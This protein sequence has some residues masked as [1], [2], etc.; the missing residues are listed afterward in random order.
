M[1]V[2]HFESELKASLEN[3]FMLGRSGQT[4]DDITKYINRLLTMNMNNLEKL[5]KSETKE[6]KYPDGYLPKIEYWNGELR[7]AIDDGSL[8]NIE[9][10]YGKLNYFKTKQDN[11]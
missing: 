8:K 3:C 4:G 9:R 6:E 11:L 7:K 5:G 1:N 10:C 2:K